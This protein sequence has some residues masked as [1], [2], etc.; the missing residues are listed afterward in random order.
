MK[1]MITE[2]IA[3]AG[4][5]AVLLVLIAFLLGGVYT[6]TPPSGPVDT[7]YKMNRFT[8]RVWLIKTYSK[9]MAQGQVRVLTAREA[10]VEKTRDLKDEDLDSFAMNQPAAPVPATRRR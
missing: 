1:S 2:K 4:A 9:P 8:G 5:G 6:I 7:A 3:W 10:E